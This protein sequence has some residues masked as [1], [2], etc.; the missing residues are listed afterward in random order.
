M[1]ALDERKQKAHAQYAPSADSLN[2]QSRPS[3]L[4]NAVNH[5]Q[6]ALRVLRARVANLEHELAQQKFEKQWVC[7][8]S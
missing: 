6:R 2:L 8:W 3:E 1:L 7:L 5:M 4:I